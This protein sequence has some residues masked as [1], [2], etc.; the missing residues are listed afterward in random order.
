M[1]PML[2]IPG[3]T[4]FLSSKD[5]IFEPKLD[6]FRAIC[7]KNGSI[8]LTSRNNKDL[9]SMFPELDISKNILAKS[10]I[11]DGEI[12]I[13]NKNGHP[14]FQLMQSRETNPRKIKNAAT[15]V[16]F[17]ILEKEGV[18]LTN[19]PLIERKKILKKTINESKL[20]QINIFTEN[21]ERLWEEIKKRK[22]EGVIAKRKFSYYHKYRSHDWIKIK[23][24][25]TLDAVII[26]YTKGKRIISALVLGAYE[27]NKIIYI[28][29]VGTGFNSD[30][31]KDLKEQLD[32]IKANKKTTETQEKNIIWVKPKLVAEIKYHE[33]TQDSILRAPVFLR[34]RSDKE[35][36]ECF[37]EAQKETTS[38]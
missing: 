10:A 34:L 3:S 29:K 8:K 25:N 27:N 18:S 37:L 5:F 28:G 26:G 13:Y 38:I 35:A 33:F 9:T 20:I 23:F 17:D 16:V 11:L 2:S 32:K 19:L 14:D 15:Y 1:K 12:I 24:T 36:K 31:I 6:G 4:E 21:G 30:T 7:H 22:L